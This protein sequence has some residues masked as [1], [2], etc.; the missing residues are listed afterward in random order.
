MPVVIETKSMTKR[1]RDYIDTLVEEF[2]EKESNS[3][4]VLELGKYK[5]QRMDKDDD[6]EMRGL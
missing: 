6:L 2:I 3:C 1:D 4:K 5:I